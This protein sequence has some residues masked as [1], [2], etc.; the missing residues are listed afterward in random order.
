MLAENVRNTQH[1]RRLPIATSPHMPT[2]AIPAWYLSWSIQK[3]IRRSC[4]RSSQTRWKLEHSLR[5][6]GLHLILQGA[7]LVDGVDDGD[8]PDE[9]DEGRLERGSDSVH[10]HIRIGGGQCLL[11]AL[12]CR[13]AVRQAQQHTHHLRYVVRPDS[14]FLVFRDQLLVFLK[15]QQQVS[16]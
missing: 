9:D 12:L 4:S 6:V 13:H 15:W 16:W 11:S 1:R 10:G 3:G 8:G 14:F 5:L 7:Y 2:G